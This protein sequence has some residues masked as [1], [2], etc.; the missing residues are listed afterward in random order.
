MA[1]E[2]LGFAP[3]TWSAGGA[4]TGASSGEPPW[5]WDEMT[6]SQERA[7]TFLGWSEETWDA[8]R[9]SGPDEDAWDKGWAALT[10]EERGAA[11][12]LGYDQE[13]WDSRVAA[14]ACELSWDELTV[15]QEEAA[16]LLGWDNESWD[17]DR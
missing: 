3:G 9:G 4:S 7:A 10:G 5:P 11:S 16:T 6:P 14:A 8:R 15:E 13:M 17:A 1:A 2:L 12:L